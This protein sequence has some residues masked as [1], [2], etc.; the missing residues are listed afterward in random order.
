MPWLAGD[1]SSLVQ[2]NIPSFNG[3]NY[4]V[5]DLTTGFGIPGFPKQALFFTDFL[6]GANRPVVVNFEYAVSRNAHLWIQLESIFDGR[7]KTIWNLKSSDGEWHFGRANFIQ[8]NTPYR[9]GFYATGWEAS[10]VAITNLEMIEGIVGFAV[11]DEAA[12]DFD[13]DN[14]E[15]TYK[16]NFEFEHDLEMC[17]FDWWTSKNSDDSEASWTVRKTNSITDNANLPMV[18]GDGVPG[19]SYA[20]ANFSQVYQLVISTMD[21]R[22]GLSFDPVQI[23]F[24]LYMFGTAVPSLYLRAKCDHSEVPTILWSRFES[25]WHSEWQH[26]SFIVEDHDLNGC[27]LSFE[28]DLGRL[29]YEGVI[30]LD[31]VVVT[32]VIKQEPKPFRGSY[33]CTFEDEC[34]IDWKLQENSVTSAMNNTVQQLNWQVVRAKEIENADSATILYEHVRDHTLLSEF[35]HVMAFNVNAT[36]KG[37][38]SGIAQSSF[39]LDKILDDPV[40]CLSFSSLASYSQVPETSQILIH[41]V[42]EHSSEIFATIWQGSLRYATEEF[43]RVWPRIRAQLDLTVWAEQSRNNLVEAPRLHLAIEAIVCSNQPV[44][45][46]ILIDDI[47]LGST[48]CR[49]ELDDDFEGIGLRD[50][51]DSWISAPAQANFVHVRTNHSL[52]YLNPPHDNTFGGKINGEVFVSRKSPSAVYTSVMGFDLFAVSQP[53]C[54]NFWLWAEMDNM[55]TNKLFTLGATNHTKQLINYIQFTP[56]Y[57]GGWQKISLSLPF[58]NSQAVKVSIF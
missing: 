2:M 39:T 23:S 1:Q 45:A 35:G 34:V 29:N 49:G 37:C 4:L 19:G 7:D 44:E 54:F 48:L 32:N 56:K 40:Q 30:A 9:I 17:F 55:V 18:D 53:I 25:V 8:P 6:Y 38:Y 46:N 33:M 16:C 20:Y 24:D 26:V 3:S 36:S 27:K 47:Y 11:P 43:N 14:M 15:M 12:L 42:K 58:E 5:A 51:P 57:E 13:R 10:L 22:G 52:G 31:N 41:L 21:S 50:A 28:T